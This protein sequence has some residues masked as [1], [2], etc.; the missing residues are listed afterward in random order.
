MRSR[1]AARKRSRARSKS[2]LHFLRGE[3]SILNRIVSALIDLRFRMGA[4][5]V[6]HV[7]MLW[8]MAAAAGLA[9]QTGQAVYE[10]NC[11]GCHGLDGHGGEQAP[12]IASA[13]GVQQLTGADLQRI[14]RDGVRSAGMPAFGSRLSAAQLSA[15]T[16]Y[17]RTLQGRQKPATQPGDPENGRELFFHKGG[18]SECHMAAGQGGFLGRDL[19]S[20]AGAHSS[21]QIRQAILN[22]DINADPRHS[23]ATVITNG[24]E[25]YTG[26]IRNEDNSSL[27]LQA[28]NGSFLLLNKSSLNSIRRDNRSLMPADYGSKLTPGDI[29]NLISYLMQ[30]A[31]KQPKQVADHSEW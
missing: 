14:V 2:A 9:Q 28:L 22:P 18:C 13:Q 23:F 4:P 10:S 17:V 6:P 25:R 5:R 29:T 26:V 19:S 8:V 7:L 11:A 27:Q 30:T 15:V 3:L 31:A 24:G 1:I 16:A 12:N 20:Y 21:E